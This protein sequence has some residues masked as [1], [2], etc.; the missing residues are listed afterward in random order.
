MFKK[1]V[2]TYLPHQSMSISSGRQSDWSINVIKKS[3]HVM[4]ISQ[5]VWNDQVIFLLIQTNI[6]K[7]M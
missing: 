4:S 5:L 7:T 1:Q 2:N 3:Y 6:T